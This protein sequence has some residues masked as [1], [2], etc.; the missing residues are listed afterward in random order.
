MPKKTNL[1][2]FKFGAARMSRKTFLAGACATLAAAANP[3][4]AAVT[5]ARAKSTPH[6]PQPAALPTEEIA[7]GI[8]VH[9]G[10]HG[11]YTPKNGGDIAN[12]AFII[13]TDAVALIDTG[14]TYKVGLSLMSAVREK[15]DLPIRYV[16]N[17]HMHPDHVFGNAAFKAINP[18]FIAHHKM[19]RGLKARAKRYLAINKTNAGE[20]AFE[21]TQVVL[22]TRN[23]EKRE[24]LDLGNRELVL[25]PQPTAHTDNDL[26]ITD[27]RTNTLFMGDLLFAE[28]T[29]A[30]DGSIL[31]WLKLIDDLSARPAARVVPG[32]G[33]PSM[34]WPDAIKPQRR[35]LQ[36][37]TDETRL[38]IERG[39]ALDEA[40]KTV[41]NHEKPNW[42]LFEEF[43]RRNI[44]TAFA[45]LEWE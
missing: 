20:A 27:T 43:H 26:I 32:H 25:E 3:A 17:T 31:G 16:I 21:G 2:T 4:F 14:G 42:T 28:H 5:P 41:A 29:P 6:T 19:A 8:F 36:A 44:A 24:T 45:E 18:E 22:P 23:I 38:L 7:P 39:V 37:I 12:V 30:L 11:V 40:M 33:P 34:R 13:G 9:T 15:T 1:P 10:V 35:Y